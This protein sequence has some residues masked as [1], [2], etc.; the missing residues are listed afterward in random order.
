MVSNDYSAWVKD[1]YPPNRLA[2]E[3]VNIFISPDSQNGVLSLEERAYLYV[4]QGFPLMLEGGTGTG[5]T[6]LA[7]N[8]SVRLDLPFYRE[9]GRERLSLHRSLVNPHLLNGNT[10]MYPGNLT[11]ALVHEGLFFFEEAENIDPS[12]FVEFHSVL[13]HKGVDVPTH[14][15]NFH[16]GPSDFPGFRVVG[17]GNFRYENPAFSRATLARFVWMDMSYLSDENFEKMLEADDTPDATLPKGAS[18]SKIKSKFDK[19]YLNMP[20]TDSHRK[21]VIRMLGNIRNS[22]LKG[23]LKLDQNPA[24][25]RRALRCYSPRLTVDDYAS[26]LMET[27]LYPIAARQW[28]SGRKEGEM[29]DLRKRIRKEVAGNTNLFTDSTK[30]IALLDG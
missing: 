23:P 21:S 29:E 19:I 10:V 3:E 1:T 9:E 25:Y 14:Y 7:E 27:V 12:R 13:Q 6:T 18:A 30:A 11:L 24:C 15:G 2:P 20:V 28:Y 4:G 8:L 16:I 5:K 22:L 17:A 26:I